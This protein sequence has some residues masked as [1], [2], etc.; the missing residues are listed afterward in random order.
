MDVA[1]APVF[2]ARLMSPLAVKRDAVSLTELVGP[3]NVPCQSASS[4]EAHGVIARFQCLHAQN[5]PQIDHS[6][7]EQESAA[8]ARAPEGCRG[9][10]GGPSG[11][12]IAV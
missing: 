2:S 7:A 8:A 12:L 5:A 9:G 1:D 11:E 10:E 4:D 3:P 6:R